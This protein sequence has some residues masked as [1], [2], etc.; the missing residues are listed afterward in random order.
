M[1]VGF[2]GAFL[3]ATIVALC[4]QREAYHQTAAAL[5]AVAIVVYIGLLFAQLQ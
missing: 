5:T 4:T 1:N 2:H 3:L